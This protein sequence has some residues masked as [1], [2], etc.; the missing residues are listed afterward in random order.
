MKLT[1]LKDE[2]HFFTKCNASYRYSTR[3]FT[4]SNN[5]YIAQA[6][7]LFSGINWVLSVVKNDKDYSE[8]LRYLKSNDNSFDNYMDNTR[9]LAN[10]K[11]LKE[12]REEIKSNEEETL[13]LQAKAGL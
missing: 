4:S 6:E 8:F 2:K 1:N 10:C 9:F 13:R 11:T 7:D 12:V 5:I 3:M